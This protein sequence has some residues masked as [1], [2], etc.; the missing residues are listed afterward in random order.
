MWYHLGSAAFGSLI[1]AIVK[2][3]RA[4]VG[5]VQADAKRVAATSGN[6]HIIKVA[7]VVLCCVQCCLW[8]I[9]KC[10]KFI[11]KNAYIQIAIFSTSFCVSAKN[12]FFLIMR[13]ILRIAS[14]AVVDHII[15]YICRGFV[16]VVASG[17]C[18]YALAYD[19]EMVRSISSPVGPVVFAFVLA[20]FTAG[21]FASVFDMGMSTL[22]QC[23]IADEE[24]FTG[25]ERY[26]DE[27]L[28]QFFDNNGDKH[29]KAH[30]YENN[31]G[32]EEGISMNN[33]DKHGKENSESSV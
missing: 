15:K 17:L 31:D 30:R 21:M 9:E 2:M 11:N 5:K 24:M 8:C 1:I 28:H 33:G 18:Y 32:A 7:E 26:A 14:V 23:F 13:N 25:S 4:W 3:V 20:W 16:A 22:I 27:D 6:K 10:L 29:G 19:E 12:A